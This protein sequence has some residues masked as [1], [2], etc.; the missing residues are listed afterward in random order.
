MQRQVAVMALSGG[1]DSTA[2][3]MRLLADDYQVHALSFDYGQKH[4]VELLRATANLAYL[5]QNGQHVKHQLIDLTS[6]MSSFHSAL[7]DDSIQIPEG[8]Y[9]EE[10]MKQTVVPNRNAIFCSILYGHALSIAIKEK[11]NVEIALGIHSG[12]HAIYPDCRPDFYRALAG[13]FALG[14]WDSEFVSFK[15]PY[16]N[17]HKEII[18]RDAELAIAELG[19]DFDTVFANTNT[20]YNP[21]EQ[22]RS[23]G[24]SGADVE[25]I[26]AFHSIGRSDPVPYVKP[27]EDVLAA[28]LAV[29]EN[30]KGVI[31]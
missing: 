30:H 31:P 4:R 18:L 2:L 26:L 19:L 13:A 5:A 25:R 1:M 10:Q 24:T 20:S 28:A 11:V 8:H 29:E 3:L 17:G 16:I 15:L 12:D 6:A 14:N 7:T 27:W 22:G 21:D 23:A 9:E